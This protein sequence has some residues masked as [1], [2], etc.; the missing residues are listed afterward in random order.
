MIELE[1]LPEWMRV[2][3]RYHA[4]FDLREKFAYPMSQD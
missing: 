2:E 3:C 4:N 1:A